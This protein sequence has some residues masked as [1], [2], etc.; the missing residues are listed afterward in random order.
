[1]NILDTF[2]NE[3]NFISLTTISNLNQL[4]YEDLKSKLEL[5]K[6]E[7]SEK[8]N[9]LINVGNATTKRLLQCPLDSTF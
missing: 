3:L 8:F 4:D 9:S 2:V 5:M 6:K 1:M 7:L